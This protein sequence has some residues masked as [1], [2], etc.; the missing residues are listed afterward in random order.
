MFKTPI[1]NTP[2]TTQAADAKFGNI[3]GDELVISGAEDR[4]W[5]STAR[6]LVGPRMGEGDEL[7]IR[8]MKCTYNDGMWSNYTASPKSFN[9]ILESACN[10]SNFRNSLV[11]VRLAH[12]DGNRRA[13]E[14]IAE[15]G[16]DA[17]K[18]RDQNW[19]K[20]EVITT[21]FEKNFPVVCF[22]NPIEKMTMFF[23]D[24][25]N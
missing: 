1:Y 21:F 22:I 8:I 25:V 5:L 7:Y 4:S 13:M 6:A 23:V 9:S 14:L 15:H 24:D 10:Y 19:A 16:E 20:L 12:R 2:F 3:N 11:I 18:L 17:M